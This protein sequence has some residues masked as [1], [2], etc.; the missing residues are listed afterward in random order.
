[1]PSNT[2]KVDKLT[3]TLTGTT[4]LRG[5]VMD[6][7]TGDLWAPMAEDVGTGK[8]P[9]LYHVVAPG[10]TSATSIPLANATA[11]NVQLENLALQF[12]SGNKL[13]VIWISSYYNNLFYRFE[14]AT[15]KSKVLSVTGAP[16]NGVS[17]G[18]VWHRASNTGW[19]ANSTS[20]GGAVFKFDVDGKITGHRNTTSFAPWNLLEENGHR[21][22]TSSANDTGAVCYF[23]PTDPNI[24]L[25]EVSTKLASNAKIYGMAIGPSGGQQRLWLLDTVNAELTWITLGST[26]VAA[27]TSPIKLTSLL[28]TTPNLLWD[29]SC[30]ESGYLWIPTA[31]QGKV[32]QLNPAG[33][34]VELV[35]VASGTPEVVLIH[36]H[37]MSTSATGRDYFVV[38]ERSQNNAA[39]YKLT[40]A[41]DEFDAKDY[42]FEV[43]PTPP[44][45]AQS[46]QPFD[47]V[48]IQLL[49]SG[50]AIKKVAKLELHLNDA[51]IAK[52]TSVTPPETN[53]AIVVETNGDGLATLAK[54]KLTAG[55]VAA[56]TSFTLAVT[57]RGAKSQNVPGKV[58][59]AVSALNITHDVAIAAYV[60][61]S[62]G[63]GPIT[64]K[65]SPPTP[66]VDIKFSLDP[67]S[68]QATLGTPH[69][70]TVSGGTLTTTLKAGSMK[71]GN[72]FKVKAQPT[73][74]G[75]SK[76]TGP[77]YINEY[78]DKDHYIWTPKSGDIVHGGGTFSLT[79]MANSYDSNSGLSPVK[80]AL[81]EVAVKWAASPPS[82]WSTVSPNASEA[83]VS[84]GS[85]R[86]TKYKFSTTQTGEVKFGVGGNE[87]GTPKVNGWLQITITPDFSGLIGAPAATPVSLVYQV[88]RR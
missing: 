57:T 75:P 40:P 33:E 27:T 65:I 38:A 71:D 76:E 6:P 47:V 39:L 21:I 23:D 53:T 49:K 30:D 20:S 42:T 81:F 82:D 17:R 5:L 13:S 72:G 35:D 24:V 16:S 44:L 15:Q 80:F 58:T 1:M 66:G 63:A 84:N 55:K 60:N 28:G 43:K 50:T 2:I 61:Q 51:A 22:W 10:Y 14:V 25:T 78:P 11:D 48:T 31:E 83:W 79:I 36:H 37:P 34:M 41:N 86:N 62:F 3:A 46:E 9:H 4:G 68:A 77:H 70:P 26:P 45:T 52:F 85:G 74:G 73:I 8:P 59:T 69:G 54:G 18:I 7:T 19:I 67:T 12:D 56:D 32:L 64:A 87:I 88:Q 29:L